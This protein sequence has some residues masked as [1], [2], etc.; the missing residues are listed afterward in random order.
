MIFTIS[1]YLIIE[2]IYMWL[3]KKKFLKIYKDS[4]E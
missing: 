2:Y 4:K 3:E 1:L